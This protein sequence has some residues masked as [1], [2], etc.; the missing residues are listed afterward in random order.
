M[1][2]YLRNE[3]AFALKDKILDSWIELHLQVI[4]TEPKLQLLYHIKFQFV[5]LTVLL[6]SFLTPSRCPGGGEP[7]FETMT[8]INFAIVIPFSSYALNY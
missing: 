5:V 8:L 7:V 2:N 6:L 4:E 1:F 3:C